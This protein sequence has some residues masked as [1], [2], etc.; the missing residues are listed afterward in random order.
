MSFDKKKET[1]GKKR[2]ERKEKKNKEKD[3][4]HCIVGHLI[5]GSVGSHLRVH[6]I[7]FICIVH[8]ILFIMPLLCHYAS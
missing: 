7:Y 1:K 8:Y 2:E 5:V 3:A 6:G 4:A